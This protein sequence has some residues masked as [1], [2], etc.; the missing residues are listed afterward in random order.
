MRRHSLI[1]LAIGATL[2]GWHAA[3]ALAQDSRAGIAVMR[4]SNG[5]SFGR[6]AEDFDA[7]EVGL[8]QMMLTEFAMNSNLRVIERSRIKELLEEQD[9][10]ATGRVDANT[11]ARLGKLVGARYM[12]LGGFVE[13]NRNFRIDVRV[14]DVETSEI[15][16]T[17]R[18]TDDRDELYKMVVDL[19]N[20]LTS[21]LDLPELASAVLEQRQSREVPP[22]AVRYYTRALLWAERGDTERAAEYYS[23]ALTEFPEYT[24]AKEGLQELRQS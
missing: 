5:G 1:A 14:V 7:L 21:D 8:Q 2:V 13:L 18:V 20:S 23:R 22:Q 11:A 3:Q 24:E 12:I 6:E 16:K 15:V 9:L 10:G 4:F 19:A 17:G